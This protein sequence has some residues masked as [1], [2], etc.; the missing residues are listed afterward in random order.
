[1]SRWPPYLW[2]I[3]H[4]SAPLSLVPREFCGWSG[5]F[6]DPRREFRCLYSAD[7]PATCFREKLADLR[8]NIEALAAIGGPS[9]PVVLSSSFRAAT[10]LAAGR[11]EPLPV[12]VAD[13]FSPETRR[14]VMERHAALLS[15]FGVQYLDLAEAM[16]REPRALTQA[17]SRALYEQG[18]DAIRYPSLLDGRPCWVLFE[19]RAWLEALGDDLDLTNAQPDFTWIAREY[20]LSL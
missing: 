18:Y 20:N 1:M 17:V 14:E 16:V 15:S 10:A 12:R 13:L 9:P 3:G 4:I 5:R 7:A 2:R 19:G 6:D 11:V 8:P